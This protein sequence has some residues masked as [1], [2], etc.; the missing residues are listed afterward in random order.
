MHPPTVFFHPAVLPLAKI[1]T[2]YTCTFSLVLDGAVFKC[3][4]KVIT[5]LRWWLNTESFQSS[6]KFRFSTSYD[7]NN[8]QEKISPFWLVNFVSLWKIYSCLFIPN[9]TRN[10]VITYT[11]TAKQPRNSTRW[12]KNRCDINKRQLRHLCSSL[13]KAGTGQQMVLC[14]QNIPW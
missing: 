2:K 7:L 6:T 3:L 11:K 5:R 13:R 8:I 9:C 1:N 10:H 14:V 4:S 12:S